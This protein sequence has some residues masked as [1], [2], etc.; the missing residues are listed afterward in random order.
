MISQGVRKVQLPMALE[1]GHTVLSLADVYNLEVGDVIKL[2]E[3]VG[4]S[5]DV[6]VGNQ[7]RFKATPGTFEGRLAAE[8]QEVLQED[9]FGDASN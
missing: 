6:R 4:E 7:I 1:L 9:E 5:I 2:D 3:K 8:I